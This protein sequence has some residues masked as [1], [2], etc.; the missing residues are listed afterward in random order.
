[1]EPQRTPV[2]KSILRWKNKDR[3]K[4]H[5][6]CLQ[7]TW[8]CYRNLQKTVCCWYKGRHI[9]LWNRRQ[10]SQTHIYDQMIFKNGAKNTPWKKGSL[11]NN[12]HNGKAPTEQEKTLGSLL[13]A[14]ELICNICMTCQNCIMKK[15]KMERTRI[16]KGK[17]LKKDIYTKKTDKWPTDL[18]KDAQQHKSPRKQQSKG[19]RN[20]AQHPLDCI[21]QKEKRYCVGKDVNTLDPFY[22]VSG[23]VKWCS[24]LGKQYWGSSHYYK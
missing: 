22:T 7:H 16:K 9:V 10:N 15:K 19:Q 5:T 4:L 17:R 12:Q 1:M 6:F 2:A 3:K 24:H 21:T 20:T 18:W 23:H 14:K 8:Q 13:S 11:F